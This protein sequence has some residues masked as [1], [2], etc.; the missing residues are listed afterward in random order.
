[1]G[2]LGV[3]VFAVRSSVN[4]VISFGSFETQRSFLPRVVCPPP[5]HWQVAGLH[6][7]VFPSDPLLTI[8]V[9]NVPNLPLEFS[10]P[11]LLIGKC[12]R[13]DIFLNGWAGG[14]LLRRT[15]Y[16][17]SGSLSLHHCGESFSLY[18]LP[19]NG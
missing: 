3:P 6:G 7:H 14:P 18:I 13:E 5:S 9:I 17:F 2:C 11:R 19:T 1:M 15:L 16:L 12:E 10:L 8:V 4:H